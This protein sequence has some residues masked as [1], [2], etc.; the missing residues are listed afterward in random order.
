MSERKISKS[1]LPSRL[2]IGALVLGIS[3]YE[4][5]AATHY[6]DELITEEVRRIQTHKI[7]NFVV[8]ALVWTMAAHLSGL[9]KATN[10]EY[11]DPYHQI[12]EFFSKDDKIN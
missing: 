6:E 7:G 3:A 2:A 1:H 5:Y 10:T 4:A 12:A 11:L 9:Y 8:Q